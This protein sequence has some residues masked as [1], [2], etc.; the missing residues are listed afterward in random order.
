MNKYLYK[1]QERDLEKNIQIIYFFKIGEF[2]PI[3]SEL[4]KFIVGLCYF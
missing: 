1:V 3:L 4:I 2:I